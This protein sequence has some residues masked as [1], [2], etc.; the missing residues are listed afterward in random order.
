M[1]NQ[2]KFW[3]NMMKKDISANLH[4]NKSPCGEGS[5]RLLKDKSQLPPL[6][7]N[8]LYSSPGAPSSAPYLNCAG[9]KGNG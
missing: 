1:L 5:L 7:G 2:I 4:Q 9:G 6:H 8:L 3:S